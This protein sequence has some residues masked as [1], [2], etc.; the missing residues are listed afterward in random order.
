MPLPVLAQHL[1]RNRLAAYCEQRYPP[2]LR[3]SVRLDLRFEDDA[4]VLYES[5]PA[6]QQ[7][8]LWIHLDIARFRYNLGSGTWLLDAPSFGGHSAWR[9]YSHRPE[10]ELRRLLALLDEDAEGVFWS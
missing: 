6:P 9:Q 3:E 1:A 10:R 4:V 2:E 5:R 7:A 8:G